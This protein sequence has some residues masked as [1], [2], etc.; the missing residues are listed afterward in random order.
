MISPPTTF[1][2]IHTYY[3]FTLLQ[4]FSDYIINRDSV[5]VLE[6][7]YIFIY[8]LEVKFAKKLVFL[9]TVIVRISMF[10]SVIK[11]QECRGRYAH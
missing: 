2:Q 6:Q 3:T 5:I 10:Q 11:D 7:D 8:I 9:I 4:H 1:N